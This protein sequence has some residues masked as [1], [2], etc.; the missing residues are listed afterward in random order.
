VSLITALANDEGY[1]RIFVAQLEGLLN[2]GDLVV[3]ISAS[4][5]SPNLV[6]ALEYANARGAKTVAITGFSGGAMRAIA[7]LSVHLETP[8]GEYGPVEDFHVILDHL[9]TSYLR[10]KAER[11]G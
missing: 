10:M 7:G 3:A 2:A 9:V 1:E 8:K 4:G 6:R 11:E 5:N